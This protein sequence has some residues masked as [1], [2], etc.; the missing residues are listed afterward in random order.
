MTHPRPPLRA[1]IVWHGSRDETTPHT[2]AEVGPHIASTKERDRF[3]RDSGQRP[4]HLPG[5]LW[6]RLAELEVATYGEPRPLPLPRFG[7]GPSGLRFAPEAR[8]RILVREIEARRPAMR[9]AALH[10]LALDGLPLYA[11][12]L[13]GSGRVGLMRPVVADALAQAAERRA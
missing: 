2:L 9:A 13:D 1:P 12:A 3:S 11:L 5:Q 7:L 8:R 6:Q 4:P 10:H